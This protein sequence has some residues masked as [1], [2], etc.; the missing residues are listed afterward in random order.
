M[1]GS[2][3]ISD[4]ASQHDPT[5]YGSMKLIEESCTLYYDI[6]EPPPIGKGKVHNVQKY[7]IY[8]ELTL[9]NVELY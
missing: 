9:Y 1:Y 3:L 5:L 4:F 6:N 7:G 8:A 2:I